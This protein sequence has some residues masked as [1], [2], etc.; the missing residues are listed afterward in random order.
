MAHWDGSGDA[1]E[2]ANS[3]WVTGIAKHLANINEVNVF[4][5]PKSYELKEK[6][7]LKNKVLHSNIH[8]QRVNSFSFNKNHFFTRFLRLIFLS[9]SFTS[10]LLSNVKKNDT[11]IVVTN[12]TFFIPF[13]ALFSNFIKFR[14]IILVHDV[15]PENLVSTKIVSERNLF[16]RF[17]KYIYNKSFSKAN[18]IVVCGR[19]M[20]DLFLTK[21]GK[22]LSSKIIVIENWADTKFVFP[23]EINRNEVYKNSIT[24]DK[25]IFQFAGNLGRLQ[26]LEEILKIAKIIQNTRIHFVIIGEGAFKSYLIQLAKEMNLSNV[27][28]LNSFARDEQNLFLNSCDVG[29]VSLYDSMFGLGV[30]SKTYNLMA[31]GKPILYFGNSQSEIALMIKENEIGWNFNFSQ[32]DE[33]LIFFNNFDEASIVKK[34]HMSRRIAESLYSEEKIIK[35][36]LKMLEIDNPVL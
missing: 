12:P 4:C 8:I 22:D 30:P 1:L 11:V 35:K 36:Y 9:L 33:I 17:V 16:Y 19:D 31:A 14:L 23:T 6:K 32:L 27:T 26:G 3:A 21:I 20:K 29:I 28:F 18:K 13:V 2:F 25:I 10:K 5:G 34:S 24:Q 15:F 7:S